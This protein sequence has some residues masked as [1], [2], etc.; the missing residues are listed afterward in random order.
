VLVAGKSLGGVSVGMSKS[1]VEARWG[2]KH[3]RC[4]NCFRETWYFTYRPFQPQGAAVEFERG[5]VY[6]LYTLWQPA[7]WRTG[8]GLELGAWDF[9]VTN[10]YGHLVRQSCGRYTVQLLKGPRVWTV[11]SMYS[12]KVWG[13]GLTRAGT[14]PCV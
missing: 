8:S 2:S 10:H 5:R 14:S 4:R 11:F 1:Q 3:G 6:R 12:G 13:F 9:E 7:G